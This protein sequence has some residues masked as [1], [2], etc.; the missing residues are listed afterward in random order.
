[1]GEGIP[2][3]AYEEAVSDLEEIFLRTTRGL[4]Q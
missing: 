1:V 2:V 3:F 4:V